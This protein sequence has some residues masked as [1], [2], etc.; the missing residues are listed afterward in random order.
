MS[1]R[2]SMLPPFVSTQRISRVVGGLFFATAA[3]SWIAVGYDL[4]EVRLAGA[5]G[6]G[7]DVAT[8]AVL[9]HSIAGEIIGAIQLW[10]AVLT[11]AVFL[12]WLHRV[13]VNVRALGVR[14]LAYGREWTVLA[15]LVPFLNVTRP[16]AVVR[17]I[18]KAS[19]P[20]SG[21]PLHWQAR[22]TPSRLHLWWWSFVAYVLL[23]SLSALV[24]TFATGVA[25]IKLAHALGMR[26]DACAALSASVAYFVVTGISDAQEAKRK[27]WGAGADAPVA[28]SLIDPREHQPRASTAFGRWRAF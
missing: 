2:V 5:I 23:E 12:V 8:T 21:D 24:L 6:A 26:D 11:A 19:D 20:G 16:F 4:S 14:R 13:R 15:F 7:T 18:W 3:I 1:T 27:R 9:S 10:W 17:E 25:R 28:P 22:P